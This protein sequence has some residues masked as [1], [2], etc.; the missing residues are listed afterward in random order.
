M[1]NLSPEMETLL[2]IFSCPSKWWTVV[3][4]ASLTVAVLASIMHW[5]IFHYTNYG[6]LWIDRVRFGAFVLFLPWLFWYSIFSF[7]ILAG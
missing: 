2:A 6:V 5:F 3:S 4:L 1:N 7:L